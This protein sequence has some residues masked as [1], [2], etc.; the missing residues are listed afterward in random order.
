MTI[1]EQLHEENRKVRS[2][3]S[4]SFGYMQAMMDMAAKGW[5]GENRLKKE[6]DK[7][8]IIW[9]AIHNNDIEPHQFQTEILGGN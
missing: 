1:N 5:I 3:F 6:V 9:A 4:M 8:D 2:K 7:L